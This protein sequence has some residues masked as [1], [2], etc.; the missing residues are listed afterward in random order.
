MIKTLALHIKGFVLESVLTPLF[1]ILEVVMETIIPMLL[2]LQQTI[3]L[4]GMLHGDTGDLHIFQSIFRWALFVLITDF[5]Q[6]KTMISMP[7]RS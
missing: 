3:F 6:T 7:S 1:M 2:L 5:S 4:S